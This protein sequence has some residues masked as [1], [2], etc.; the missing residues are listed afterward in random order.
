MFEFS[1]RL[2]SSTLTD[3]FMSSLWDFIPKVV[4]LFYRYFV[5]TAL[6]FAS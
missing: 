3:Y 5:P 4:L 1:F 6:F 2:F